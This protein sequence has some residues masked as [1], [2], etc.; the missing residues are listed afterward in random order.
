MRAK[1]RMIFQDPFS[2]L[3]P[4]VTVGD[5]LCEELAVHSLAK[6][7]DRAERALSLLSR[8]GLSEHHLDR[9]PYE[10]SG[11]QL[12]RIAV[13]RAVITKP[14]LIVRDEPVAALDMSVRAQVINL[15]RDLQDEYHMGYVFI[16]HDLSLV[17]LIG[18]RVIVMYRGSIVEA[19]PAE[20]VFERPSTPKHGRCWLRCQSPIRPCATSRSLERRSRKPRQSQVSASASCPVPGQRARNAPGSGRRG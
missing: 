10:F 17:R 12:Q 5:S 2:S 4:M 13:A 1:A 20:D 16:S 14:D 11:G 19:G 18:Q 7:S 6:R 3:D 9:F 15:L 8:V